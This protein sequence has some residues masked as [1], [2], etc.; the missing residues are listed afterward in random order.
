MLFFFTIIQ[1]SQTNCASD[2]AIR[3]R[4]KIELVGKMQGQVPGAQTA[5]PPPQQQQIQVQ[6]QPQTVV[7]KQ[8]PQVVQVQPQQQVVQNNV[9]IEQDQQLSS[10]GKLPKTVNR[11]LVSMHF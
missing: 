4:R 8:Q 10:V 5:Q 1:I 11:T 7:I 9:K 3:K 2:T 6:N